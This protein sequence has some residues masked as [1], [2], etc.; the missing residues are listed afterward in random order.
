M[1]EIA[2]V[3]LGSN[4]FHMIVARIVNGS[5]QILSRLKQKVQLA[6]GLD[7]NQILSQQAMDRGIACL[8]L[9]S[10][11]LQGFPAENVQVIGTY[12]LRRALNS[13]QFLQQAARVFPYKI[14]IISGQQEAK[15]IYAGV[16]HTQP[17]KGR[18]LVIDIGGGST[19]MVIGDDFTP[20]IAESRH[21]GC[22]SFAK[23]FFKDGVISKQRFQQAKQCA[24]E[25]IEDLAW[26]Y[27][28]LGW[29][30]ALGSSGTIKTVSEV[31]LAL[32]F[33]DGLITLER[34]NDLIERTLKVTHFTQL[35]LP[36]LHHNRIDVFVPG[37]AILVALFET[38]QIK[39]MRYSDGAVR[40]GVMYNFEDK[41]RVSNIRERTVNSLNQ[42][43]NLDRQQAQRVSKTAQMLAKQFKLWKEPQ[44]SDEMQQI[45]YYGA[46]THEVGIVINHRYVQ[47]H[48]AYIL[49]N[50]ELPGFDNEQ[51]RLLAILARFHTGTFRIADIPDCYRYN[52]DDV[53]ALILLLRLAV[54]FNKARQATEPAEIGVQNK[55]AQQWQLTF[56]KHYLEHNPLLNSDLQQEQKFLAVLGIIFNYQ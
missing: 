47:K 23:R 13:D 48:S 1:K 41:F 10:E 55:N 43:F 20:L 27:R 17:E 38:F 21:M 28:Q 3:D 35:H 39:S 24:L 49:Q 8:A 9:F 18:K 7:Q 36:G 46:L 22:V 56:P 26:E 6:E 19:E 42:Q 45:L 16:S 51:Q 54:I 40:E 34:L 12:T 33:K 2:V 44:Y 32:H 53:L 5:I 29:D 11:R 25:K 31:L 30:S 50:T 4:S 52:N 37:L 15:L 14:N